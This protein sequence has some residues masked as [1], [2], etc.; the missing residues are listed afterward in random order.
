MT[1]DNS[2]VLSGSFVGIKLCHDVVARFFEWIDLHVDLAIV[3]S[4]VFERSGSHET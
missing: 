1:R 2:K 3:Q 4:G